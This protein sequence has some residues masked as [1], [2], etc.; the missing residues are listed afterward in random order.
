MRWRQGWALRERGTLSSS[1]EGKP[2]AKS[3]HGK[4]KS[5]RGWTASRRQ[6]E[7]LVEE[8]LREIPEF[9]RARLENV[10]VVVEEM[11]TPGLLESLGMSRNDTLLGLYEGIPI[12]QRGGWYN[13][14]VPD[15]IIL[16]R[17]PILAICRSPKEVMEQVRLTVLHE[18]GHF[19]GIEEEELDRMGYS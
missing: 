17:R 18:V 9:L 5:A 3:G 2:G 16:F 13:L 19:Y 7:R 14:V 12:T 8:V 4:G 6:F 10:A 15:R 11:P 1:G